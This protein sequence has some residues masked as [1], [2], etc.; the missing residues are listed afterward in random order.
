MALP[1]TLEVDPR[2]LLVRVPRASSS[3]LKVEG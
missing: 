2:T 3:K 1:I